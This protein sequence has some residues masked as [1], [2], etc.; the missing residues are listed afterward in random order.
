MFAAALIVTGVS[1]F[2]IIQFFNVTAIM[3]EIYNRRETSSYCKERNRWYSQE[4]SNVAWWENQRMFFRGGDGEGYWYGHALAG[5]K[6]NKSCNFVSHTFE[7]PDKTIEATLQQ[8]VYVSPGQIKAQCSD[9]LKT[10]FNVDSALHCARNNY[11]MMYASVDDCQLHSIDAEV[12]MN[13]GRRCRG[14]KCLTRASMGDIIVPMIEGVRKTH[15]LPPSP[16]LVYGKNGVVGGAWSLVH[17]KPRMS[18]ETEGESY[19][20][21]CGP[22]WQAIGNQTKKLPRVAKNEKVYIGD[23]YKQC[24]MNSDF[25]C[26]VPRHNKIFV[27]DQAFHNQY[28]HFIIEV[29][30]RIAPFLNDIL[31]DPEFKIHSSPDVHSLQMQYMFFDLLGIPRERVV[32]GPVFGKE[33]FIPQVGYSHNPLLNL[34]NLYALRNAIEKLHGI[35]LPRRDGFKAILILCRDKGRRTDD[36][37][38]SDSFGT[39]IETK[40][41]GYK[42]N[43]FKASNATLM[44]CVL[45]QIKLFQAADIIIGAHGAGLSHL[46][47]AK[48]G[49]TV[50]EIINGGGDSLIYGEMAFM[51]GLKYFPVT[52]RITPLKIANILKFSIYEP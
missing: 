24:S 34:W 27:I 20:T 23:I 33:V 48:R 4:T 44:H 29:W 10:R 38:L 46:M 42:I 36:T 28:F 2:G 17:N 1:R 43:W 12:P 14:S 47:W 40:L 11:A 25:K 26:T 9:N 3:R 19:V 35:E 7:V 50:I 16:Y 37:F 31:E 18:V 41:P 45:C 52:K 8:Q 32:S 22:Y 21:A 30:P 6:T 39:T 15:V 13:S 5:V 49:A 51:F